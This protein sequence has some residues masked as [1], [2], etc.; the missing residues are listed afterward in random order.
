MKPRNFPARKLKR[1][2]IAQGRNP[3][4]SEN[5]K[6]LAEARNIRT[7]KYRGGGSQ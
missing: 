4:S 1:Q 2:M 7:K 6:I 5:R 3:D